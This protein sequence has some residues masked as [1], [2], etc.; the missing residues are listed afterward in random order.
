MKT[1]RALSV[2]L[3]LFALPAQADTVAELRAELGALTGAVADLARELSS[4]EAASQPGYDGT[5]LDRVSRMEAALANLT[6][7]TEELEY[8]IRRTIDEASNRLGDLEFRVTELEGGSTEG[9]S[10]PPLGATAEAGAGSA[11]PSPDTAQPQLAAGEQQAFDA[12]VAM[13]DAGQNDSAALALAQFIETYPGSP[14][15]AEASLKL[16][17]VYRA[18][19]REPDA[20]RTYLNLYL[21]GPDGADAPRALLGL[22][23]SLGR[24]NQTT[25]ACAMFDELRMRFA[26]SAEATQAEDARARLSCP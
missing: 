5:L 8:R 18:L 22:G 11:M 24:L 17:E 7:R 2:V 4:G 15:G 6:G 12:A 10:P 25:E 9:L 14:L 20:A 21:T 1:L 26:N 16:A 3:C 13:A 19:G 23:E